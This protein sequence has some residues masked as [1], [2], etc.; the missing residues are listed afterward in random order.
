MSTKNVLLV[1][2]DDEGTN[3]WR[4]L[5]ERIAEF[6][7]ANDR[8]NLPTICFNLDIISPETNA[9]GSHLEITFDPVDFSIAYRLLKEETQTFTAD[10]YNNLSTMDKWIRLANEAG[11][12]IDGH[13]RVVIQYA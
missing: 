11:E 1:L 3:G 12:P 7:A 6:Q 4:N 10:C 13:A 2:A 8:S 5:A 9:D